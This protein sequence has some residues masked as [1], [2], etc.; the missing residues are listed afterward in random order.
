MMLIK[1]TVLIIGLR[2]ITAIDRESRRGAALDG[3]DALHDAEYA[4]GRRRG[5]AAGWRLAG[6]RHRVK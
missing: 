3:A 4:S 1:S 2:Q 5:K 6:E